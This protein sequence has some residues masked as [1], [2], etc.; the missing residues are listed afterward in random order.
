[1]DRGVV[2]FNPPMTTAIVIFKISVN[3]IPYI[4]A[5]NE[6]CPTISSIVDFVYFTAIFK[7]FRTLSDA[8][9]S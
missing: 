9:D 7:R 3:L 4:L 1:M 5:A 2:C 8:R 6:F